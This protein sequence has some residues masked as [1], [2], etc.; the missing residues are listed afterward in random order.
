[1]SQGYEGID[2]NF[3]AQPNPTATPWGGL[4]YN[5]DLSLLDGS[6]G[7]NW[8]YAVGSRHAWH[9]IPGPCSTRWTCSVEQA[10][11]LYVQSAPVC[12]CPELSAPA[13]PPAPAPGWFVSEASSTCTGVCTAAGL[14][15]SGD[16][17]RQTAM[18]LQDSESKFRSILAGASFAHA[19]GITSFACGS[20]SCST[21][22]G[23]PLLLAGGTCLVSCADSN[24]DH[25]PFDC[26]SS[27]VVASD[28]RVCYCHAA[29]G[30]SIAESCIAT[31]AAACALWAPRA[32]LGTCL[33]GGDPHS[34][35]CDYTAADP[36]LGIA[37]SC[38]A[39]DAAACRGWTSDGTA[40]PCHAAGACDYT[41]A[42]T[43]SPPST[44]SGM[45]VAYSNGIAFPTTARYACDTPELVPSNGDASRECQADGSWAGGAPTYCGC[46]PLPPK[47]HQHRR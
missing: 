33:P 3:D 39:T 35:S 37:E 22:E 19:G 11:E 43:S 26:E 40:A 45:T 24:G 17:V 21:N 27:G 46:A 36:G 15:C 47:W 44:M 23:I 4:E 38:V 18:P 10:V 8:Y 31:D 6:A 42:S 25:A 41:A 14:A 30:L 13:P 12:G 34:R 1:M 9:G 5:G 29:E 16:Y 32:D 28:R 20:V 7:T 2:I